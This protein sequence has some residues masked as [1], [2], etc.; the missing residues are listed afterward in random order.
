MQTNYLK[1]LKWILGLTFG[2]LLIIGFAKYLNLNNTL[3]PEK[4]QRW[5]AMEKEVSSWTDALGLGIDPKIKE[6]VIVLNLLG[7]KT[8]QS[9]EGHINWGNAYPWVAFDYESDQFK[10]LTSK[11]REISQ[12]TKAE[13]AE[14]KKKYSELTIQEIM[15]TKDVSKLDELYKQRH[16]INDKMDILSKTKILPLQNLMISFYAVQPLNVDKILILDDHLPFQFSLNSNGG[17]WQITRS[18]AEKAKKLDEYQEE[19]QAFTKFLR[20]Y[21]FNHYRD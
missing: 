15:Q 8:S 3:N 5:K 11:L 2:A 4:L 12:Q 14:L 1:G 6:T 10:A 18:F 7:F 20:D 19:M 16:A 9:C 21:Y 17:K 13:E